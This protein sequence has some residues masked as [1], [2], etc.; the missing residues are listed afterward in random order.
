MLGPDEQVDLGAAEQ[1][2]LGAAVGGS[3]MIRWYSL[4]ELSAMTPTQS[5][6]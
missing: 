2:A 6:W 5:S 4:R 1:D 3:A